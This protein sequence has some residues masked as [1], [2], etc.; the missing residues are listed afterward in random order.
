LQPIRE[1]ITHHG[2]QRLLTLFQYLPALF[3]G[4]AGPTRPR[5]TPYTGEQLQEI[6]KR[7]GCGR[8]PWMTRRTRAL[9]PFSRDVRRELE[10]GY[11]DSRRINELSYPELLDVHKAIEELGWTYH[12]RE[13][14]YAGNGW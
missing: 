1:S 12:Q 9:A 5:R 4:S 2:R 14:V 3:Q 8:P 10:K 11:L 6:R 7:N 13:G